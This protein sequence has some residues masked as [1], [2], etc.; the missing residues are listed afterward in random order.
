MKKWTYRY[1]D[2]ISLP[3]GK[4]HSAPYSRDEHCSVKQASEHENVLEGGAL[5][6]ELVVRKM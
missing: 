2:D 4:I 6:V 1:A 5:V 3:P